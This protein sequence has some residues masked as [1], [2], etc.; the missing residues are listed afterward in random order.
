M[1]IMDINVY[2]LDPYFNCHL[3]IVAKSNSNKS[4]DQ[5]VTISDSDNIL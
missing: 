4:L 1:D 2:I 3:F 5:S